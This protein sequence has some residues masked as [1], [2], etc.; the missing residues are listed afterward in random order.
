MSYVST[1][2]P[3][4]IGYLMDFRL[5]PDFPQTMREDLI[6][7]FE[8]VFAEALQQ[9]VIDRPIQILYREPEGLPKGSVK[10][11]IDAYGELVEEGCLLVYGPNITDN[12]VPT[13]EAI[14]QRF[15]V[16][17]ISVTGT[18]DWLGE[19]TFAFPMGS[20]T[21]EPI[22]WADLLTKRGYREV[23]VLV[24]QSLV[25]ESYLRNFRRAC[26]HKDIRIVA[27]ASIAQTAQDVGDAVRSLHDAKAAALVHCGFGFGVVRASPVLAA[28]GWDPPRFTGTAFQNA[29]L[30][31]M[32]WNALLG[33][34]GIDQYDEENLVG[35]RFLDQFEAA[36]GRR[37]EY[38]VPVVNRDIATTLLHALADAHP[39]S[40]RGVK[41]A[42]E[43]V[44]MLP[45]ASGA[46]GT[47]ISLGKWGRRAWVGAGYLVARRLDPDGVH[48]HRVARFGED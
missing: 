16:P 23:G 12:A 27:E 17:A 34:T 1:A 35:Q 14:E 43:R 18:E 37:P 45:A 41:E 39:L 31:P 6:K 26:K 5:P 24:E 46:P 3:I 11:V 13:R 22:F 40:P 47:R 48:S 2:E 7:P 29:W 10:A 4:K 21:D 38:C 19:W 36:C 25:G 32:M 15:R 44:K 20:M 28:L 30:H 8:L 33:W 42:L 9:K